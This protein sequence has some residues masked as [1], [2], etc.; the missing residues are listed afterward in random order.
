MARNKSSMQLEGWT[1]FTSSLAHSHQTGLARHRGGLRHDVT[2]LLLLMN[3]T[4]H[5]ELQLNANVLLR[6][7]W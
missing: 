1:S 4:S 2:L 3:G 5:Q 6:F 7:S